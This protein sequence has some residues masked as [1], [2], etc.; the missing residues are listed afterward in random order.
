[1]TQVTVRFASGATRIMHATDYPVVGLDRDGRVVLDMGSHKFGLT[2]CCNAFDKGTE[3]G[4]CC[5]A[6]YGTKGGDTGAYD[7][8]VVDPVADTGP[9]STSSQY[10][11]WYKGIVIED[12]GYIETLDKAKTFARQRYGNKPGL[13]VQAVYP[14]LDPVKHKVS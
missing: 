8:K 11:I 12:T 13:A 5:R 4:V 1:M 10:A 7:P 3:S 14:V 6:C 2:L 9:K